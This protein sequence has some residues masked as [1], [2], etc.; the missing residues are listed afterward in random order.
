MGWAESLDNGSFE[1]HVLVIFDIFLFVAL[2]IHMG[3][4]MFAADK[5]DKAKGGKK[6][7]TRSLHVNF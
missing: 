2:F 3:M 1:G 5:M 4:W 6:T 7:K